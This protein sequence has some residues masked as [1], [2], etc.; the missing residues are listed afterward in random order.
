MTTF[1]RNII[2]CPHCN[3]QMSVFQL[4]SYTSFNSEYFSDGKSDDMSIMFAGKPIKICYNCSKEFWEDNAKIM[5][6]DDLDVFDNMP[7]VLDVYD[8]PL[9]KNEEMGRNLINYYW[10]LL[11]KGFADTKEHEI[12]LRILL[13]Q[14]IN[15]KYRYPLRLWQFLASGR[16][17]I[18]FNIIRS[19]F[20]SRIKY[21]SIFNDN[22][23]KLINISE[24][25]DDDS[26]LFIAEM[27]RE[28]GQHGKCAKFLKEINLTNSAFYKIKRANLLRKKQV[29]KLS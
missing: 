25:I 2:I 19:K 4:M 7:Q 13:W 8:L 27:Y 1:S 3:F 22:L 6:P 5:E 29:L 24:V 11:D 20:G 17:R 12:Y 26:R 14:T 15:D 10:K 16:I 18:A 28:L 21:R 9:L 23:R